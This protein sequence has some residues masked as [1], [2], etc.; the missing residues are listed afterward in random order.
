[1]KKL[2]L[3]VGGLILSTAVMAQKP[4][5]SVHNTLEGLINWNASTLSFTSPSIRYRYFVQDNI[6]VRVT[7]GVHNSSSTD[8]FTE[9][10]DGTGGTG[11]YENKTGAM[12]FSIGGE[13]HFG[14]TDRL[15]PYAGL[16]IMLGSGKVTTDGTNSDGATF[17]DAY[18]ESS[19]AKTSMF[20]VNLVAGTDYYFAEN[21]YLGLELG[22]GWTSMTWKE[23][24]ATTTFGGTTTTS[25]TPEAKA[26][27]LNTGAVGSFRLGWRF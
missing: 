21:F 15:S 14:G 8:N 4:D 1:M 17:I 24:E 9:F 13:Y 6:A 25:V 22:L 12:N 3:L 10:G 27:D 19:E 26:S 11:T 16:D 20:G 7:L 18:T 23:G 2:S 5:A